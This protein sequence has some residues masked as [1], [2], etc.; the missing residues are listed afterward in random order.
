M[1]NS[2]DEFADPTG[3]RNNAKGAI[4]WVPT[5][6]RQIAADYPV[7]KAR[8]TPVRYKVNAAARQ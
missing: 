5:S 8:T 6:D 7:S 4:R 2:G 3:W 1:K